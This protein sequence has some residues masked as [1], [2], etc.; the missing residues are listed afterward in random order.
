M[1]SLNSC[2]P[3]FNVH[4]QRCRRAGAFTLIELLVVIAIIAIIAGLLL[5]TLVRS[6]AKAQGIQCMNN[7]KQ[8]VMAWIL[9]SGDYND[10]LPYNVPGDTAS[11]WVNGEM[12]ES[13]GNTQ[14]TNWTLL[15]T[16][17]IGPYTKDVAV[18]RCPSDRSI[19]MPY[20]VPRVR[21]YSM[22]FT[23]GDKS[24]TGA[25]LSTYNDYWPNFFR[26]GDFKVVSSTWVFS[27][28]HPDSIN[29]GFQCTPT[30]DAD[31]TVWSDVPAS[32]HNNAGCY[33]FADG[34][35]EIHPWKDGDTDHAVVNN[36]T[37]LPFSAAPPYLDIRWVEGR[38]S[39]RLDSALLGQAPIQ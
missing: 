31:T 38:C 19:A 29:D 1:Q 5:P 15:L 22:D 30:T 39:P 35:S 21:S 2:V 17:Q 34:H 24:P 6:K 27:E 10:V 13:A 16:G 12:S 20:G 25:N 9:Y 23:V 33:S 14:N 4:R 7:T 32:F 11:G 28:E 26:M 3:N 36:D 18:Y 8:L 37:W